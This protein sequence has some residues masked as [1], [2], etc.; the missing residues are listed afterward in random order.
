MNG[1]EILGYT[2]RAITSL[3][4][5]PQVIK[6]LKEKSARDV[7]MMMFI[8]AVVNQTMWVVYGALLSNWVIILTNAVIL[9]MSLTMIILKIR[10]SGK[11]DEKLSF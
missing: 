7:S 9:S 11:E 2:A 3:T 4:F 10:Y 6:T 5:L 8:I 1:I